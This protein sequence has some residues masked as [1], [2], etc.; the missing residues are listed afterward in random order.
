MT[1]AEDQHL[2]ASEARRRKF[3][4]IGGSISVDDPIFVNR[5]GLKLLDRRRGDEQIF[6]SIDRRAADKNLIVADHLVLDKN[7]FERLGRT[8]HESARRSGVG[9]DDLLDVQG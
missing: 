6:I 1:V 4:P 5:F 8:E 9:G 3:F 7:I 2:K